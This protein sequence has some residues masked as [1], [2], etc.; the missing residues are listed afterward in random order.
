M[1]PSSAL[2][3]RSLPH[4]PAHRRRAAAAAVDHRG[5]QLCARADVQHCMQPASWAATPS[6]RHHRQEGTRI[7]CCCRANANV[8][9]WVLT[10]ESRWYSGCSQ[11][12]RWRSLA[13]S[14]RPVQVRAAAQAA[15]QS[16]ALLGMWAC[17]QS[18]ASGSVSGPDDADMH[19]CCTAAE[20]PVALSATRV[21]GRP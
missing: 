20:S 18:H 12:S 14:H 9:G 4:T 6:S 15:L 11:C 13:T 16:A 2:A 5:M 8:E 19:R 3:L 1:S 7:A 17:L 21:H 10:H